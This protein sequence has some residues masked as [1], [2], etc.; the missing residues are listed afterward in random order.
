MRSF[1]CR[2]CSY[3]QIEVR[4]LAKKDGHGTVLAEHISCICSRCSFR[5]NEAVCDLPLDSSFKALNSESKPV[6]SDHSE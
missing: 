6:H 2:K 5:W 4:Y 3:D 1:Q